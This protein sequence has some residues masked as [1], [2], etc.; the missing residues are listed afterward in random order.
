MVDQVE[1]RFTADR[2]GHYKLCA[3]TG[4]GFDLH[5]FNLRVTS[6]TTCLDILISPSQRTQVKNTS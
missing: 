4:S 1:V 6:T 3:S 5:L 2:T